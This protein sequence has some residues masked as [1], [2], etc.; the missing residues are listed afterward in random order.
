MYHLQQSQNHSISLPAQ[1]SKP[2]ETH[3]VSK[4]YCQSGVSGWKA[5]H[6]YEEF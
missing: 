1:I 5:L 6:R 4:Q 2:E 3:S